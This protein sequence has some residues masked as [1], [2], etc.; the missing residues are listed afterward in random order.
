MIERPLLILR[1]GIGGTIGIIDV[2]D[3]TAG[4]MVITI[5]TTIIMVIT[6]IIMVITTTSIAMAT[7][8]AP[9]AS[10]SFNRFFE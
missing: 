3:T 4:V 2:I 10:S 9:G 8:T 7:S 1:V 5:I 6:T